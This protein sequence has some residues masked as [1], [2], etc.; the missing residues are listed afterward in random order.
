[1]I[2]AVER[3]FGTAGIDVG[4]AEYMIDDRDGRLVYYD[5]NALS[6]FV[7]D[8]RNVIGF[9]PFESLVDYLEMRARFGVGV[10]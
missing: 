9:D 6:N 4:G 2:D 3:I 10:A 1:V 5:V 7:A 8:A